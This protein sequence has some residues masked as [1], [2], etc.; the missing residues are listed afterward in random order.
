[1]AP[2]KGSAGRSLLEGS[3]VFMPKPP[4]SE[5]KGR[6]AICIGI[7][8]YDPM[9]QLPD[10]HYAENDACMLHTSLLQKGFA[11]EHCCL[12][13]GTEATLEAIQDA[14]ETFVLTK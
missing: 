8:R 3:G 12:L 14:L 1:M 2:R 6:Y 5:T 13:I 11:P 4:I 10:L 7:N 9:A